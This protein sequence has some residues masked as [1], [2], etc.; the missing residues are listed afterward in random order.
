MM[1]EGL[2]ARK[3]K[4]RR[5]LPPPSL[6]RAL[7]ESAGLTQEDV[8]GSVGV[9]RESVSRWETGA[10]TPRGSTLVAYAELLEALK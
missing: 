5:S 1:I 3:V 4:A 8:A 6:R 10:R 7:R 2:I 9:R